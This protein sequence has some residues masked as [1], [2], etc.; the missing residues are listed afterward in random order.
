MQI[1]EL[2]DEK[3]ILDTYPLLAQL[4]EELS[5]EQYESYIKDLLPLGYRRI[6]VLEDG[7]AIASAGLLEG[8]HFRF[9]KY[10]YINDLITDSAHRSRGIGKALIHWIQQNA[11]ERGCKSIK[12]ASNVNRHKAH[13]FYMSDDFFVHG[14]YFVK[15]LDI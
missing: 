5:Y 1:I 2:T 4:Y 7:N 10:M 14:Y 15:E 8:V 6:V 3:E 11:I 9:G 12:L 13:R